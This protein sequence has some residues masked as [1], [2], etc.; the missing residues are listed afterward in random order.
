[1]FLHYYN[2]GA[3]SA[4]LN[5]SPNL[6]GGTYPR[7]TPAYLEARRAPA[8][9]GAQPWQVGRRMRRQQARP[10]QPQNDD[11][12]ARSTRRQ[13]LPQ[14][15]RCSIPRGGA[16]RAGSTGACSK[17]PHLHAHMGSTLLR[18]GPRVAKPPPRITLGGR[19]ND[20]KGCPEI[21]SGGGA[22]LEGSTGACSKRPHL[23]LYMGITKFAC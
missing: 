15:P 1:M 13:R 22:R 8:Q 11:F 17:G 10:S 4:G 5:I 20:T 18:V 2:R 16:R 3:P 14:R 9:P 12:P 7:P 19:P 21:P 6:C 23:H